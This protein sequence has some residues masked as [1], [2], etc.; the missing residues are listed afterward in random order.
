MADVHAVDVYAIGDGLFNVT[1][2]GLD[3]LLGSLNGLAPTL[4]R[5][6]RLEINQAGRK[7]LQDTRGYAGE[8]ARTGA[9]AGSFSMRSVKAGI[10]IQSS[11]V[12]AGAIEFAN[13]GAIYLRG[14]KYGEPFP[15]SSFP[16]PRALIRASV[17]DEGWVLDRITEAIQ[18][19]LD[20]VEGS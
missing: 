15:A 9:Y 17:N 6:V 8:Y 12:A 20:Q 3:R 13:P 1:I 4:E 10:R 5:E 18:N 11:D 16:K 2:F 14:P 19:A 7:V